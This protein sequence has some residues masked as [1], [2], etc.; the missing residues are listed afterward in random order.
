MFGPPNLWYHQHMN[1]GPSDTRY[2]TLHPARHIEPAYEGSSIPYTREDPSVRRTFE[3]E[4]AR[5]GVKN[6]MPPELYTDPDF[7]WRPPSDD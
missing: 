3:A 5:H 7:K 4:L 1:T 6:Q 2:I